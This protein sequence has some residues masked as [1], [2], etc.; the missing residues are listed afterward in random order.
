MFLANV[1]VNVDGDAVIDQPEYNSL[2]KQSW[3]ELVPGAAQAGVY[4][5]IMT[6]VAPMVS[7]R[8]SD[9]DRPKLE[10]LHTFLPVLQV[11][12]PIS[13]MSKWTAASKQHREILRI[14]L[15]VCKSLEKYPWQASRSTLRDLKS[16][17]EILWSCKYARPD[18]IW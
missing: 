5:E 14:T 10:I 15:I 12:V 16:P 17:C 7:E 6:V 13:K 2:C 1:L 4:S 9:F 8:A 18:I 3:I 11:M